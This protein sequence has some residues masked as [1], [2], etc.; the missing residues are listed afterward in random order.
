MFLDLGTTIFW[1]G[2]GQL[3]VLVASALVPIRLQW[4]VTLAPLPRLVRQLFWIYGGYIVLTIVSLGVVSLTRSEDLASGTPL[5]RLVC[6][7]AALFWGVRLTLQPL[8]AVEPFLTTRWL[9]AGYHLLT[10]LFV[11]FTLVFGWGAVGY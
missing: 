10:F 1:A 7:Y 4:K 11:T 9:R 5:A 8:L 3:D 2:L 6:G